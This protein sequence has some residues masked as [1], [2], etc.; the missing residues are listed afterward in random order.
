[1]E[2][3]LR[4]TIDRVIE[5]GNYILGEN[6]NYFERE[7]A[8]YLGVRQ[9]VAVGSG[10]DALEF[11]LRACDVDGWECVAPANTFFAVVAAAH[12]C[13]CS[14][15]LTDVTHTYNMNSH[16]LSKVTNDKTKAIIPVHLYGQ[17]AEFDSIKEAA[18]K[19]SSFIIED[20]AQ[21]HGATYKG[22][23][24]G[25]LGDASC[26]SFYPAKNLGALGDGGAVA[27]NDDSIG[28]RVRALRSYG[29]E[30]KYLHTSIGRNSRLDEI[31]AA[32]LRVKLKRLDE[33]NERRRQHA[34]LYDENLEEVS[35]V[36]IPI[37][38]DYGKPVF[39]LYV[40]RC[41]LRD[42]LRAWLAK[43]GVSVGIH[44]P[45][46]LHLQPAAK[47]LGY[48]AGDF[49]KSE[50]YAREVLSLPMFPELEDHEISY[51]CDRIKEFYKR[52]P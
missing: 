41:K 52:A 10:T 35:Q 4:E 42:G 29:E 36:D 6:V 32:V 16:L 34:R 12:G 24:V 14:L 48:A 27:T 46:P 43:N 22:H 51:V 1:M 17:S 39:H 18:D 13:N 8:A 33:W 38:E 7:F 37:V 50:M 25:A 45:S 9:V 23:H 44:Y 11:A 21:A 47:H 40:I 20:A 15:R 3:E 30:R 19:H 5:S 28:D 49:P 2:S 31:Q 26:F